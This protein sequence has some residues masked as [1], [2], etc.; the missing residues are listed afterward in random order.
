M[1]WLGS[2]KHSI[3]GKLQGKKNKKNPLTPLN[4]K[5]EKHLFRDSQ[6]V[7][8]PAVQQNKPATDGIFSSSVIAA[9]SSTASAAAAGEA[10]LG[11]GGFSPWGVQSV[12]LVISDAFH[13]GA[14]S[15]EGSS[16]SSPSPLS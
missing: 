1:N 3:C 11:E 15:N 2:S 13:F 5:P 8:F 4:T 16:S 9:L 12:N 6:S 10:S 14:T 7:E